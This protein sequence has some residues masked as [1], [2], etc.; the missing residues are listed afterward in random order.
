M[1]V[2]D[3]HFKRSACVVGG[4]ALGALLLKTH[5][6]EAKK[7]R[8]EK[9]DPEGVEWICDLIGELLEDWAPRG[10]DTE[11]EYTRDL[12][13]YLKRTVPDELE[14]DDPDVMTLT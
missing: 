12:C 8:A 4:G 6:D 9:D 3:E 7:S 2:D 13:R 10:Y 14:E 5:Y 1:P 11:D